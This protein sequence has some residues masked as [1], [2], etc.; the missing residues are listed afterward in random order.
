[1]RINWSAP[2]F[3]EEAARRAAGRRA[4]N[5]WRKLVAA[6]RRTKVADLLTR[7]GLGRGGPDPD[8]RGTRGQPGHGFQGRKE[9]EGDVPAVPGVWVVRPRRTD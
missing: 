9:V 8:R 2:V 4:Y 6:H 7:Y 3:N 5:S 1:V